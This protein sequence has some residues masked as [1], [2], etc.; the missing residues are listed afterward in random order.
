VVEARDDNP[1]VGP[2]PFERGDKQ[3]FFGRTAE[4]RELV[5]LVIAHRLVLLYAPSGAGKTSLLNAALIPYLEREEQFEVFPSARIQ[6]FEPPRLTSTPTFMG[7]SEI[8][9]A[10]SAVLRQTSVFSGRSQNS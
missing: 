8:G 10:S 9:A 5:S 3:R 2:R 4:L 6:S 1:Y 7:L